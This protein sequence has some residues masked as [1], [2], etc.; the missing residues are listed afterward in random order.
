M[1][2]AAADSRA[3]TLNVDDFPACPAAAPTRCP[4]YLAWLALN[5]FASAPDCG[6]GP[7]EWA[8]MTVAIVKK[9]LNC[10]ASLYEMLQ[11]LSLTMFERTPLKSAAF[12]A[13]S[14]LGRASFTQ[15]VEFVRITLGHY[16]LDILTK[17]NAQIL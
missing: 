11:I 12:A 10:S 13:T 4:T 14:G 17:P 16:W 7:Y 2:G 9:R 3:I 15:P 5:D 8:L 1:E 6:R